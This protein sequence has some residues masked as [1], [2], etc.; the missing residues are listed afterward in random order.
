MGRLW[1]GFRRWILAEEG[2]QT[3]TSLYTSTRRQASGDDHI[4]LRRPKT[5]EDAHSCADW[6]KDQKTVVVNLSVLDQHLAR[7]ALDFLGGVI[8]A[9]DG[10]M[11]EAGE[12]IYVL[13]PSS[14][15]VAPED[16]GRAIEQAVWAQQ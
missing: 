12:G 5:L 1:R 14:T 9:I 13:T 3:G 6:L 4:V 8:F 15:R 7:R 11:E 10:Q 16:N 2:G